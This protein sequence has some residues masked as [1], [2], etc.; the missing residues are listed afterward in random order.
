[1]GRVKLSWYEWQ[2]DKFCGKRTLCFVQLHSVQFECNWRVTGPY[3]GASSGDISHY[4]WQRATVPVK[5]LLSP[6]HPTPRPNC[7]DWQVVV[8]CPIYLQES[9]L[10]LVNNLPNH[11][12]LPYPSRS[13]YLPVDCPTQP[14]HASIHIS[15]T[16]R[17]AKPQPKSLFS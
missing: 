10:Q 2:L 9:C 17:A 16:H 3:H 14:R 12:Y 13:G 15:P 8:T 11:T 7:L 4:R 5:S 1:M 6:P